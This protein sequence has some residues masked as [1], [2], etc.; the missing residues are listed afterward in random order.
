MFDYFVLVFMCHLY[1][2]Q[3]I[4]LPIGTEYELGVGVL[5][6]DRFILLCSV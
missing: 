1:Q 2:P 5:D 4:Y 3:G 6:I